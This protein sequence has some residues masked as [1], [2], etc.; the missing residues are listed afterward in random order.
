MVIAFCAP[1]V[2]LQL[3]PMGM[4]KSPGLQSVAEKIDAIVGFVASKILSPGMLANIKSSPFGNFSMSNALASKADA[5]VQL[6]HSAG[7]T[8]AANITPV[9]CKKFEL[10]IDGEYGGDASLMGMTPNAKTVKTMFTKT[11]TRYD[12]GSD[13]CKSV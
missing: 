11:Y 8:Q 2:E 4:F 5:Y 9:P 7:T 6:I 13:F 10:K 12:P 1:R 3:S